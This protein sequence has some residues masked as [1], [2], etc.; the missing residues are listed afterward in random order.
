MFDDF[1]K[2]ITPE[3]YYQDALD[4]DSLDWPI[5][6]DDWDDPEYRNEDSWYDPVEFEDYFKD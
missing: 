3:E 1:D 6:E 2:E 5:E 4:M